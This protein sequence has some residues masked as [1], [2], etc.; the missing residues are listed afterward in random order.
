MPATQNPTAA[1]DAFRMRSNGLLLSQIASR[2]GVS[3]NAARTL[4]H[5]HAA[6]TGQAVPMVGRARPSRRSGTARPVRA[7][8]SAVAA[9]RRPLV[10]TRTFGIEVECKGLSPAEAA[11]V[12]RNAGVAAGAE[13]YGHITRQTW[14]V[15]TDGSLSGT[16]AEVVSPPL[17]ADAVGFAEVKVVMAALQAA[18]ARTDRECGLHVHVALDGLDGA[19]VAQ[20]VRGYAAA[21]ALIDTMVAPSRRGLHANWCGS[22]VGAEAERVAL[23]AIAGRLADVYG[24]GGRGQARYRS[25]NLGSFLSYGTVEFRQHQGTL[26]GRKA[27]AWAAFAIALVEAAAAGTQVSTASVDALLDGLADAGHL[28]ADAAAY[29]SARSEAFTNA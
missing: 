11:Q 21:H 12:L 8:R 17:P 23:S 16:S 1:A 7:A 25:L 18:G 13:G 22:L 10:G 5:R 14:K 6:D 20:V 2:L 3:E 27:V 29:L 15:T 4:V 26:S 28:A 24:P 19:Q 9:A